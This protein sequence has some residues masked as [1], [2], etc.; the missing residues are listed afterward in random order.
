MRLGTPSGLSTMSTWV[1]SSRNGMSSIGTILDTTPLLPWRPAILSPGWIL[2]FTA[3]QLLDLVEE[4]LL[5]ALLRLVVLLVHGLDLGHQLVVRRGKLPPLRARIFFK[6]R[7]GDLG[8]LLEAL[9][10]G[11]ALAV[12]QELRQTTVDVA[13]EDCLLVV[14][15]LGEPL[16]LLALDRERALVLLDAVAVEHAHLDDRALHARRHPQRGVAHVRGLL[17]EDRAQELLFRRHRALALRR[18]LAHQDVAGANLR[19]D[20]DN[21][22]LVE[23]LERF[24]RDDRNIAG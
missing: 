3:L 2:R 11:D 6:H 10:A 4:A 24:F 8:V 1:P 22:G 9:G 12:L 23:I 19:A 20:I 16:D 13:V 7:A 5:E 14:A 18:D 15:V 21:T 17:A